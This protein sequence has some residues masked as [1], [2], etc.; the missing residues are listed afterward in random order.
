MKKNIPYN[1]RSLISAM[2]TDL[3]SIIEDHF[4]N[5]EYDEFFGES[6][7]LLKSR[8]EKDA[9]ISAEIQDPNFFDLLSMCDFLDHIHL[10]NRN[11]N[12]FSSEFVKFIKSN[13]GQWEEVAKIR[14][15]VAHSRPLYLDDIIK[16]DELVCKCLEQKIVS[17]DELIRINKL[18][19]SDNLDNSLAIPELRKF[20]DTR[21]FENHNLPTPDYLDT[22]FLGRSDELKRLDRWMKTAHPVAVISGEGGLGKT[23]LALNFLY[24]Y[25]DDINCNLDQI[26]WV[27]SKKNRVKGIKIQNIADSLLNSDA[28]FDELLN[29]GGASEDIDIYEMQELYKDLRVVLVLDNIETILDDQVVE[30]IESIQGNWKVLVTSRIKL[31]SLGI[32]INLKGMDNKNAQNLLFRYS[33]FLGFNYNKFPKEVFS[34]W[35]NRMNN[36]PGYIKWF[37]H[38]VN[39][40]KIPDEV[41]DKSKNEFITF[42]HE[43][44]IKVLSKDSTDILSILVT[45][46]RFWSLTDLVYISGKDALTVESSYYS[47]LQMTPFLE[48]QKQNT[49]ESLTFRVTEFSFG[50][51]SDILDLSKD[52]KQK[53]LNWL[54]ETKATAQKLDQENELCYSPNYVHLRSDSDKQAAIVLKRILSMSRHASNMST[55]YDKDSIIDLRK[56]ITQEIDNLQILCN[57]YFE[58]Y[59]VAGFIYASWEL[60][61]KAKLNF[62]K[63]I[64]LCDYH[65]P[66]YYFAA[67]FFVRNELSNI[68]IDYIEKAYELD[69]ESIQVQ[70]QQSFCYSSI[71]N[72]SK[73]HSVLMNVKSDALAYQRDIT[74]FCE[75][76]SNT[77]IQLCI[78]SMRESNYEDVLLYTNKILKLFVN[79]ITR[80]TVSYDLKINK[81]LKF[82]HSYLERSFRKLLRNPIFR[83]DHIHEKFWDSLSNL[84]KILR[85][86]QEPLDE[87]KKRLFESGRL[88]GLISSVSNDGIRGEIQSSE[89]EKIFFYC[90]QCDFSDDDGLL[91]DSSIGTEVVFSKKRNS[92]GICARNVS[93][94][95]YE[96]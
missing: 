33:N 46:D 76:Y 20:Y 70:L 4:A 80:S 44:I 32:S 95:E 55:T 59:R 35:C 47:E 78:V 90:D 12:L 63:A 40:G 16:V 29:L 28:V 69:P 42:S 37:V 72:Y 49:N 57:D 94:V 53:A 3:R 87:Y 86:D 10:I 89:G 2:E 26:F 61:E 88:K 48:V 17:F 92:V 93:K 52:L 82:L 91:D 73:A 41:L 9:E 34:Q 67:G 85:Y 62:E 24:N 19:Q 5:I 50:F 23:A 64:E 54:N 30:F 36:N 18:I 84:K 14:N 79:D 15:K 65:A 8:I 83:N 56:K 31:P 71:S 81:G 68:F 22:T 6:I 43:N 21:V 38:S 96:N 51:L 1:V 45:S 60:S 75:M 66:L 11:K 74:R 25:I 7:N 27:Q 39:A 13:Q 77:S 58:V